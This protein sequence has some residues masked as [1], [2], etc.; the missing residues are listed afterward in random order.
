MYDKNKFSALQ[1]INIILDLRNIANTV[2]KLH[3]DKMLTGPTGRAI[4]P[5]PRYLEKLPSDRVKG[6]KK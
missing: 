3:K 4:V 6:A 1:Q 5:R 2:Y